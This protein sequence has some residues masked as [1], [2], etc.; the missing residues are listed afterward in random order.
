ARLTE[1]SLSGFAAGVEEGTA[2]ASSETR[3]RVAAYDYG[4]KHNILDLLV[5]HGCEVTVLPAATPADDVLAGGFDGVFLS[6]GPGDPEPVSYGIENVR[7][8]LGK[9]PVF[10]IC[11]G[12]QIMG[13][14]VGGRTYK[15]PF[16]HRGSNHP[17][18]RIDVDR[19]EITC[20]NHGFAVDAASIDQTAATVSHTNLNDSTVEG[21]DIPGIAFS[22]QYHPESG[23]GP[24]DARY[25]FD[26]FTDLMTSFESTELS[27]GVTA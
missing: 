22:V 19:V 18:K 20:Q 14:A 13:L 5:G 7:S 3:W 6:N 23:P 1:R 10:G 8:L 26:R 11:L 17:V 15:L 24:H 2:P 25:L 27:L 16:G 9:L 12:H 4:A 21:L